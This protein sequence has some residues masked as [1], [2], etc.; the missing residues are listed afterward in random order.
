MKNAAGYGSVFEHQ[1]GSKAQNSSR[2][3]DF[4]FLFSS[5]DTNA[6]WCGKIDP[7]VI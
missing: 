6:D 5:A 3:G 2:K 7:E 4:P 1:P